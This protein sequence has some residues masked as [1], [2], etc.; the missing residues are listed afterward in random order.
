MIETPVTKFFDVLKTVKM[1][2]QKKNYRVDNKG[3]KQ[4]NG[5]P[6]QI[7]YKKD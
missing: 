6:R 7:Q 3:F 2:K 5:L 4:P 1:G